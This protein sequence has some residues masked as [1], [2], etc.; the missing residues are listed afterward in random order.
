MNVV[1]QEPIIKTQSLTGIILDSNNTINITVSGHD[2]QFS[3][4]DKGFNSMFYSLEI[5]GTDAPTASAQVETTLR[6]ID[7]ERKDHI[8]TSLSPVEMSNS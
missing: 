4:F 7:S 5:I 3:R 1:Q 8:M 2:N 6:I